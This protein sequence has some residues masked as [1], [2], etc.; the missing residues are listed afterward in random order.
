MRNN[1]LKAAV[2]KVAFELWDWSKNVL[3]DL[4][5]RIKRARKD[6]EACQRG[7]IDRLRPYSVSF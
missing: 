1:G 7:S 2:R 5:K 4:E 6:L 3:G